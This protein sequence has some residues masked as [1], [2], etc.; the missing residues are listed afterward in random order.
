MRVA[1]PHCGQV[2]Q[3]AGK[4]LSFCGFCG[5]R[6][7]KAA[8]E[9]TT[10]EPPHGADA[11][12]LP[13]P[14]PTEE[15]LDVVA[16]EPEVV[17]GYRLLLRLGGGA[18][19][20]VYEAEEIASGRRAAIKLIVPEHVT[21]P[22]AVERFR[23][24][25]R[26]ASAIA[27]PRCVFVLAADQDAGQPYIVMELMP[28]AT[29]ADLVKEHGR[30][31]PRQA[32]AKILDV[33]EGLQEA[34]RLG[35]VHRDVK[36]SNCFLD[37][38]GRVKVGDF[39]LCK[40]VS[41]GAGA[42]G[43]L[44]GTGLFLGTPLFASPEQV[45]GE[46]VGP[47]S[48]LYS[49]AATLYCLL[50]GQAPFEGGDAAVTLA[51]IAA[52]PAPSM[53]TLRP[54][55]LAALDQV[56]LRGL[57]RDRQK[58]WQDLEAFKQALLPFLP[59]RQ[60][61]AGLGRRFGAFLIDCG[62][63]SALTWLGWAALVLVVS[64]MGFHNLSYVGPRTT[65]GQLLLDTVFW[66][67]YFV[68]PEWRWGCT[69][70]KR[71]LRLRVCGMSGSGPP[72][73]RDALVRFAVFGLLIS[74]GSLCLFPWLD[75]M[76]DVPLDSGK[77]TTAPIVALLYLGLEALGV[78]LMLATMRARNGW[79]CLHD[80][81]SGTRVVDRPRAPK[82][83]PV[84]ARP[85]SEDVSR[86][87]E[88]PER[89]GPYKV[90]GA[91]RWAYETRLLLGEDRGLGRQVLLWM[92][93]RSNRPLSATRRTCN[94]LSRLRWVGG[95]REGGWQ[96]EAFLPPV[97][98]PLADVVAGE[99]KLSWP[100]ARPILEALTEELVTAA[101][102]K[103]LPGELGVGQ[104]W[105]L[106]N[107]GVQLIDVALLG[108]GEA[109]GWGSGA[110]PPEKVLALLA[111]TAVLALE[112]CPRPTDGPAPAPTSVRAPLPMHAARFLD[113]L[114][115][116]GKPF[117]DLRQFKEQLEAT[118][119]RPMEVTEGRR[120]GQVMLLVP[121]L[122]LG[123]LTMFG[124]TLLPA[125]FH[126]GSLMWE[127]AETRRLLREMNADTAADLA[128]GLANPQPLGRAWSASQLR[129]DLELRDRLREREEEDVRAFRVRSEAA[130]G[131]TR[132]LVLAFEP[133]SET[134]ISSRGVRAGRLGRPAWWDN[135]DQAWLRIVAARK[136]F[137]LAVPMDDLRRWLV[138]YIVAWPALWVFS[139][140]V[141]R[142]GVTYLLLGLSLVRADGRPA[143]LLRCAWR[144][145]LV[146]TPVAALL[147]AAV[148]LDVG[149]VSLAQSGPWAYR[150]AELCR[151][152][153]VGL[154]LTYPIL[155]LCLPRRGPHD[156]LVGTYVVP[157]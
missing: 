48:D 82:Q 146:W 145:L 156:W 130:A 115:G 5:Q 41:G 69:L 118:A 6:L 10:A 13:P 39:G 24:E 116:K 20:T 135:P 75:R 114:L 78:G 101:R 141:F 104:V 18:M 65:L 129:A 62:I 90:V 150:L 120:L 37:A 80:L 29:L 124:A 54:E 155:A 71:F 76:D 132:T 108:R 67:A 34:H 58:R 4:H 15:V 87:L 46:E 100:E 11:P 148:S 127:R 107:G 70:G 84:A 83:R 102:E 27:H 28:G 153:C 2:L 138:T 3:F 85:L 91:L 36:P 56:V 131:L 23:R 128:S 144:A 94:R 126:L 55:L 140:L 30:L 64:W 73:L 45:R 97:G 68:L 93:P 137:P 109:E 22:D 99:G 117:R 142:G 125:V 42:A 143:G 43:H 40:S 72:P 16:A 38:D 14:P 110:A 86:P 89:V 21:S 25:G 66:A 136:P 92:R 31:P 88:L 95:G 112:G 60:G 19:G 81:V 121:L 59:G 9:S 77:D 111:Q 149:Q 147:A 134:R 157:R 151:W 119:E 103:T 1:C 152:A 35:V 98:R 8:L 32:I 12:T 53:R 96:W 44:T 105:I 123:V 79:R 133:L 50:T 7:P 113:R 51:R 33:V 49:L 154:L 122:A 17:G 74:L 57:E 106:P 63:I 26:L 47:Q 61:A 52:D 139:A